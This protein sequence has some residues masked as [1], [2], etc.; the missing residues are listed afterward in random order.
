MT[1]PTFTY[2]ERKDIEEIL[3]TLLNDN[4]NHCKDTVIAV[5]TGIAGTGKTR[6]AKRFFDEYTYLFW[7]SGSRSDA[8]TYLTTELKKPDDDGDFS[9]R[10]SLEKLED[11]ILVIDDLTDES[12]KEY[13]PETN[14][15]VIITSRVRLDWGITVDVGEMN[16]DEA[17]E[18]LLGTEPITENAKQIV[19]ELGHIPL[20][21]ARARQLNLPA[22]CLLEYVQSHPNEFDNLAIWNSA[23]NKIYNENT[24]AIQ[25]LCGLSYTP[26]DK[27]N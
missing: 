25:I 18:L 12:I 6:I 23:F 11:W 9:I 2:V 27:I 26:T 13:I 3:E 5:L 22:D 15:H 10:D 20:A 17:L 4:P 7:V 16:T 1:V 14:G 19:E 21:I 24:I 8:K